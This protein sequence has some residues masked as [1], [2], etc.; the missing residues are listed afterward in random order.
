[1]TD[2]R[3]HPQQ[4]AYLDKVCELLK[5][6]D[7]DVSTFETR[8]IHVVVKL[9]NGKWGSETFGNSNLD[10]DDPINQLAIHKFCKEVRE[11]AK[12]PPPA[13]DWQE[14][15]RY[16]VMGYDPSVLH[17]LLSTLRF[18]MAYSGEY[19]PSARIEHILPPRL[20]ASDIPIWIGIIEAELV[21]W[22]PRQG[23]N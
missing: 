10:I 9:P 19:K 18:A 21:K 23:M 11:S 22:A 14:N 17:E 13:D 16:R 2:P 7:A 5:D 6:V 4:Q 12:N 8:T 3:F 15:A 1:M 20:K